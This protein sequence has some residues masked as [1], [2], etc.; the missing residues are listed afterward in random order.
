MR[1]GPDEQ[2]AESSRREP[3][4]TDASP[5]AT[6]AS[7]PALNGAGARARARA[8]L[9]SW[10]FGEGPEMDS[11]LLVVTEL[12]ANAQRHAAGVRAFR[13]ARTDTGVKVTVED[14]SLKAPV[15]KGSPAWQPGGFG[16]PLVNELSSKVE[17]EL[18][19]GGK[20]VHAYLDLD[21]A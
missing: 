8:S 11:V 9:M 2:D 13:L 20:A 15:D 16:W 4:V 3:S 12:V 14:A 19:P 21:G 7:A 17:V 18:F 1:D 6:T 10:G 5:P